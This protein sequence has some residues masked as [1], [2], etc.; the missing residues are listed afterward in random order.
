MNRLLF[1]NRSDFRDWLTKNTLSDEGVWLV[2]GKKNGPETLK[3]SEALEEALCF[4][5]IDGLMQSVD[6]KTYIKYFKQRS[7]TSNWS[8][9]NKKLVDRLESQGLMTGYGR[10]KIDAAKQNG[11]WNSTK[12]EPLTDEQLQQF[13]DM[14][15]PHEAAHT[16]YNKMPRSARKAY[17]SSYFFGTKT[18][19]GRQKRF[20]AIVER[21]DKNLNPMESRNKD[22]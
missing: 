5:W 8:E 10:A 22:T 20:N 6:A 19:A 4:G 3:A 15:K 16:N 14:L 12:P 13:A 11:H 17:A 18:E 2:F 9:T 7:P 1:K 21:L